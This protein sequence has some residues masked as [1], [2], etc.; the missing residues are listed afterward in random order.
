M[1]IALLEPKNRE[2]LAT[3]I[4]SGQ[5]FGVN[6]V[7]VIGGFVRESYRGNIHK[8]SHQMN[9]Q[10]GLSSV[11]LM[12]F[13][14]LQDF[15]RHLPAQT[16]LVLVETLESAS[17][18]TV[19][20]HPPNATYLLGREAKGILKVEL[21]EI[22]NYFLNLSAAIPAQ[23]RDGHR[24][25][26]RLQCVRIDTPRSLNLGVCASIVMYDRLSKLNGIGR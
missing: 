19:Y 22:Q 2:N 3:V 13:E 25:T 20:E 8:F 4:R 17:S 5:N 1:N 14:T 26:A 12:Y 10:D 18:L 7:F 16:T 6:A 11:T 23:Y 24:K 15:L 9:T 21:D